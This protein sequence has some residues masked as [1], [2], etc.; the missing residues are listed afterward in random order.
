ME[1][2][3]QRSGGRAPAAT[4]QPAGAEL[5]PPSILP[6]LAPARAQRGLAPAPPAGGAQAFT[7][8]SSG[9]LLLVCPEEPSE[10]PTPH[11]GS[12]AGSLTELGGSPFAAE[13][14]AAGAAEA[15]EG[16]RSVGASGPAL[17]PDGQPLH[18]VRSRRYGGY[19]GEGAGPA[20]EEPESE[21][22]CYLHPPCNRLDAVPLGLR[23][24]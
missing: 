13:R 12:S 14:P 22:T 2:R 6:W 19:G 9:A 4:G 7:A 10:P 21:L 1:G 24:P 20:R 15:V 5:R 16:Q 11:S 23:V 3:L 18:R 17:Q 8:G